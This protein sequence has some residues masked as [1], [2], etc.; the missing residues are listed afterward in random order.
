MNSTLKWNHWRD[1]WDQKVKAENQVWDQCAME[2]TIYL[3][4]LKELEQEIKIFM[5]IQRKNL[6]LESKLDSL[7]SLV[8]TI[9]AYLHLP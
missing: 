2:T 9:S 6:E 8:S 4:E 5:Q 7:H 3:L 1:T